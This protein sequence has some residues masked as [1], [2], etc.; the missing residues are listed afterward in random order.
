MTPQALAAL[1][2]ACFQRPRPWTADEFAALI[3]TPGAIT[4]TAPEG[5]LLG[6]IIAD[7]A[8]LLTLAVRPAS[9]RQGVGR[10]LVSRFLVAAREAGATSAFLEVAS[11]NAAALAL[12]AGSGWAAVGRRRDYYAPGVHAVVMRAD[13]RAQDGGA[14]QASAG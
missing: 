2:A 11:D 14:A 13:P 8:E 10:S 9:R 7:E 4:L 5:F 3:A 6:R 12:Y 1:H